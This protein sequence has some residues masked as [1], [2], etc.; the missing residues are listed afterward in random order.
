MSFIFSLTT[1]EDSRY[2]QII[3]LIIKFYSFSSKHED[4]KVAH[5]SLCTIKGKINFTSSK[6][7]WHIVLNA[8]IV[9]RVSQMFAHMALTAY[10][11]SLYNK[12]NNPTHSGLLSIG[13]YFF[14]CTKQIDSCFC[15]SINNHRP[16]MPLSCSYHILTSSVIYW[17]SAT[18]QNRIYL[19]NQLSHIPKVTLLLSKMTFLAPKAAPIV[20]CEKGKKFVVSDLRCW[21]KIVLMINLPQL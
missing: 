3:I 21:F 10:N 9:V 8:R 4:L 11:Y 6:L 2:F 13:D 17:W 16:P 14:N 12:L 1:V 20:W 18:R 7:G 5:Y 19:N 15:C